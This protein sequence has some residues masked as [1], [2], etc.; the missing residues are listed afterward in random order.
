MSTIRGERDNALH[1][2]R[3]CATILL[4]EEKKKTASSK[5]RSAVEAVDKWPSSRSCGV[6]HFIVESKF[7]KVLEV[8]AFKRIDVDDDDDDDAIQ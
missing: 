1:V 3:T 4:R 6:K 2:G 8:V 7:P 5:E